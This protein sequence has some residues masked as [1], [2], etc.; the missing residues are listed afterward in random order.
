MNKKTG[1]KI[2]FVAKGRPR[3]GCHQKMNRS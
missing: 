3:Q 2:M 1:K